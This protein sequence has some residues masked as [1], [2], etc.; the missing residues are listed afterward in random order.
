MT[1]L[2]HEILSRRYR[3]R[4]TTKKWVFW[5]TYWDRKEHRFV[6][7]PFKDRKGLMKSLCQKAGV[8]YFRY[9]ALRHSGA[10]TLESLNVP[11][12]AIQRI[13]GH[14]NRTTTEIYL[15]SIGDIE[16]VAMDMYEK[17]R[18]GKVPPRVPP[19]EKGATDLLQ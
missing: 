8:R 19:K 3:N 14:E 5:H 12:G 7:G 9:H 1:D 13:L 11:I 10:S 4:D 18:S 15:H 16:R 2:L 17:G 6:S